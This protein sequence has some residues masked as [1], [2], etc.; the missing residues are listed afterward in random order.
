MINLAQFTNQAQL[1]YNDSVINS[2]I[3]VGEILEVIS[4]TK[5]AVGSTYGRDSNVTYVIS[6]VNSG[7]VPYTNLTVTDNLGVYAFG[8]TALVPL[9]YNDGT[10]RELT[11]GRGSLSV[12]QWHAYP[13]ILPRELY[14]DEQLTGEKFQTL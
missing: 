13:N 7:T 12:R 6:V 4:A 5:T 11:G 9:T 2:N 8:T 10:V 14:S 3:A 1:S